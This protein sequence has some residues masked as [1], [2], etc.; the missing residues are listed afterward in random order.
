V[1]DVGIRD[2]RAALAAHVARAAAGETVRIRV[3][4]RAIAALVPLDVAG[5]ATGLEQLIANGSVV[6][7]RRADGESAAGAVR[8]WRNARLDRLAREIRG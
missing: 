6:A 4:G 1:R 3:N 7:P 2:L 8:V 5:A